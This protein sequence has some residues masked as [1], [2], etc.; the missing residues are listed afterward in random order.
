MIE[1]GVM[2]LSRSPWAS[3]SHIVPKKDGRIR[4]CGD[5]RALNARTIPDRY[6]PPHIE[7]FAQ[8]LYGKRIFSEIDLVRAYHQ[9][10]IA[11]EDVEKTA[12][13]TPLVFSK[14]PT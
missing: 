13:T 1:Q 9:I 2:L 10:P 7:D 5:Y 6:T 4:P 3:P 12:I 11:P 14:R 8:D